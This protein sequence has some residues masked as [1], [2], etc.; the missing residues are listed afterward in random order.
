MILALAAPAVFATGINVYF[1][2]N[3]VKDRTGSPLSAANYHNY[4][5]RLEFYHNSNPAD[6][7]LSTGRLSDGTVQPLYTPGPPHK[8]QLAAL[9]GGTLYV[10]VWKD[11][12]SGDRKGNYYGIKSHGIAAGATPPYDW[13]IADIKTD[14]KADVPYK[15]GIGAV[16]ES[17]VRQGD[18]LK[19]KLVVP[20]SY[21]ENPGSGDGIRK[22][23]SF[24]V[25]VTYPDNS[26]ETL[27]GSSITLN[28][29]PSGTYKFKPTATNWY[30]STDGDEVVY[31][32]LGVSGGG[33]DNAVY[34]FVKLQDGL[35]INVFPIAYSNVSSPAITNVKEMVEAINDQ[36]GEPVVTAIGWWDNST[37][38]PQGY[39]VEIDSNNKTVTGYIAS[40]GIDSDPAKVALQKDM[41]YQVSVLKSAT[42]DI[43]GIR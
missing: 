28:D 13:E 42:F 38:T 7:T 26:T 4:K 34:N 31:S 21:N 17:M 27:G 3:S 15:P 25:L 37:M 14:H 29:K 30:G 10:R 40:S 1:N 16:S 39:A 33:P 6:P 36:A 5:S 12:P 32:T 41:V 20:V 11:G 22:A 35:G 43:T 23:Q 9:N 2:D 24:S 8:Y 19:L 18:E